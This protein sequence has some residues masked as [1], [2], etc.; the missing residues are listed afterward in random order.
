MKRSAPAS[1]YEPN[2]QK[3]HYRRIIWKEARDFCGCNTSSSHALL[4]PSIEGY[5]IE[6]ALSKGFREEHLHI[7]DRNPAIVATLKRRFGKIQTYGVAVSRA[8][9]SIARAGVKL[10]F[11][12]F[13]LCGPADSSYAELLDVDY[14]AFAAHSYLAVT[15]LRGRDG[16]NGWWRKFVDQEPRLSSAN[17]KDAAR[18][19]IVSAAAGGENTGIKIKRVESYK[20]TAGTQTMLVVMFTRLDF[21]KTMESWDFNSC[22][23]VRQIDERRR[24]LDELLRSHGCDALKVA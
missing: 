14:D 8:T 13:D 22:R 12:N 18:A 20:S 17:G 16:H 10:A 4:M 3:N 9:R 23:S 21:V 19:L 15:V 1:G 6:T 2:G 24:K 7:V 11:A 5:E